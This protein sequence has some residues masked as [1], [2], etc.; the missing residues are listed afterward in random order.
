MDT[1][2]ANDAKGPNITLGPL[3]FLLDGS[4]HPGKLPGAQAVHVLWFVH[5]S[6]ALAA[7]H[8]PFQLATASFGRLKGILQ[9]QGTGYPASI[10]QSL[11]ELFR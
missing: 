2:R 9:C 10:L 5:S 11:G 6:F 8:V 4:W 7:G 3:H 1:A